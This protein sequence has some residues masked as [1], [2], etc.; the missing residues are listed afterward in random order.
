MNSEET[1]EAKA[2]EK[3]KGQL[4][5]EKVGYSKTMKRLMT[6]HGVTSLEEYRAIRKRKKK[7]QRVVVAGKHSMAKANRGKKSTGPIGK[8]K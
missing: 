5:K 3:S 4:F 1:T 7:A 8:R 6:K 2:P